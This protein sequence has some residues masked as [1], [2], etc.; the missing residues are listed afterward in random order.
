MFLSSVMSPSYASLVSEHI[1]SPGLTI[2][3]YDFTWNIVLIHHA[4]SLF[5]HVYKNQQ[6]IPPKTDTARVIILRS[7]TLQDRQKGG[8]SWP[9]NQ[10]VWTIEVK[11]CYSPTSNDFF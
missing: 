6:K 4:N 9:Q 1:Q 2:Q 5:P 8:S 7:V 3:E 11:I 10:L